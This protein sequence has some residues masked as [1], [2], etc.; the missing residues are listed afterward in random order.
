MKNA[1]I[2]A[3][4]ERLADIMEIRG[5][6]FFRANAFRRVARILEDLSTDVADLVESG[7]LTDMQGIGKGTA[8]AIAEYLETGRITRYEEEKKT[9]PKGL[10]ELLSV[11]G[12]GPKTIGLLWRELDVRSMNSLKRALRSKKI[13]ELP[14]IGPKKVENIEAG[15]RVYES[16]TGRLTIGTVITSA[17]ATVEELKEATGIEDIEVAG[18][19]R[20]WRETIGDIDVLALSSK[21]GPVIEA[22]TKLPRVTE[23]LAAGTT[24]AS[25]RV[26]DGLQMDLRVVP[27]AVYGAA[28]MYFTGSQAHNVKLRG[29]A[30]SKGL[31]LS[32]YG[33]FRGEDRVAGRTEKSVMKKLG[34]GF[35]PPELREDRGEVEAALAGELPELVEL[36]DIRGDLHA[37]S[38]YSDGHSTIEEVA[39]AAKARGYQYVSINDHSRSLGVA[40]GLSVE[41]LMKQGEEIAEVN[42]RLKGITVLR[43]TEVDILSDGT[44][45]FPDEVLEELD[46]VVASIHSGFQQ[47][48]DRITGR[49]LSAIDNPHVDIIG[50]PTGR[51]LGTRPAY[52][53][54]LERV[55]KAAANTGTALE[56]NA[57][58][59]RLDLN[60]VNARRAAE[61]GVK[62]A[63][64]TDSHH[65][66]QLWMMEL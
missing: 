28:L 10:V 41:R 2:A 13:L 11:P 15:I 31:K 26:S 21:P 66:D 48:Q 30:Q 17:K 29:L 62:V 9:I 63:I 42:K 59:E 57:W 53:V 47:P 38:N 55:M 25:V 4:F 18:S 1:E 36:S 61:M 3:L 5:E 12:L 46:V 32:E 6:A 49:I 45:D 64:S 33:L 51:L 50:H 34:L 16:R 24:K 8:D 65:V 56:I 44:M 7:E 60:D 27:P 58:H 23:V 19:I 54:D 37:H 40:H 43:G 22:F 35:I 52:E 14:G 20:R 39:R